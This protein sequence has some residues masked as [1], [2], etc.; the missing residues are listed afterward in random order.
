MEKPENYDQ[1]LIAAG[2]DIVADVI[3]RI[4][5]ADVPE[6]NHRA[7]L[8]M[9]LAEAFRQLAEKEPRQ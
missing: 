4:R 2:A 3:E 5:D 7:N 1:A 8:Y 9:V 6:G